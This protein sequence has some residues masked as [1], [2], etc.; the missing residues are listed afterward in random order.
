ML[1]ELN[2]RKAHF[3]HPTLTP[4]TGYAA[5]ADIQQL[6]RETSAN[7]YS[8]PTTLGHLRGLIGPLGVIYGQ[9]GHEI[10]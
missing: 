6:R 3:P 2:L 9:T 1:S 5:Y 4:V 10:R 8:V 7:L